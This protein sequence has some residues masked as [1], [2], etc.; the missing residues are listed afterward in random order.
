MPELLDPST[1][2]AI[3]KACQAGVLAAEDAEVLLPAIRLYLNLTQILRLCLPTKL[4][5]SKAAPGVLA[6]LARAADVPDFGTLD[7]FLAET[8]TKVRA[9]FSRALGT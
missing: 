8:Q 1:A 6:L 3:E 7:P 4:D 9:I 5:P 2:R